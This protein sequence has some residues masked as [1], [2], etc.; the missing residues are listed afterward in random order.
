MECVGMLDGYLSS[1][2]LSGLL[3]SLGAKIRTGRPVCLILPA[4]P[5]ALDQLAQWIPSLPQ[6]ASMVPITEYTGYTANRLI[7]GG[8]P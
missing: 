6:E 3:D 7:Q 8:Q 4:Y 5:T 1:S 2:A